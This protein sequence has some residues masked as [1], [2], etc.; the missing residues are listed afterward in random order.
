M[1]LHPAVSEAEAY[2]WLKAQ[3]AGTWG[4]ER[5]VDLEESLTRLAGAMAA[6]SA[7]ELEDELEPLFP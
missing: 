5:V 6:V 2:L 3:A 4:A 7:V 1:R